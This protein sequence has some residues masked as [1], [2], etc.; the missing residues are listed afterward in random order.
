MGELHLHLL[1]S[2]HLI[3]EWNSISPRRAV[4]G[5]CIPHKNYL[6]DLFFLHFTFDLNSAPLGLSLAP[7]RV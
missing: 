1:E 5:D 3:L 6:F 7:V 2:V 4:T